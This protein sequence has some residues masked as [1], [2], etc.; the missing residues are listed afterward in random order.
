MSIPL[1]TVPT[2]HN[3]VLL[4]ENLLASYLRSNDE[5]FF[6]SQ[7]QLP[8]EAFVSDTSL[9]LVCDNIL[10]ISFYYKGTLFWSEYFWNLVTGEEMLDQVVRR[11]QD[12]TILKFL[13][14]RYGPDMLSDPLQIRERKGI[15]IQNG[16]VFPIQIKIPDTRILKLWVESVP[17]ITK[18]VQRKR[19]RDVAK[20]IT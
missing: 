19:K 9:H 10:S 2:I 8:D 15:V 5:V 13:T 16:L 12:A 11:L 14:D 18:E 7:S 6:Y 4:R 1:K 3:R 17:I 20:D